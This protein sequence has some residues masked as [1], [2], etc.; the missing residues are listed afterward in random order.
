LFVLDSDTLS[1]FQS[2]HQ[3][4]VARTGACPYGPVAVTVI[5]VEEQLRGWFTLVRR[6]KGKSQVA[7]AYEQLRQSVSNLSRMIILP[8]TVSA[9]D[10]FEK[11]LA[12]KI[13]VGTGDLRIAAIALEHQAIVVTRNIRD[14]IAVP[15]LTTEDWSKP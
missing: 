12:S 13:R 9:L 10:R 14:F 15:G 2:G 11:F 4:I 1:L 8:L 3:Q 5:T 6:A 7:F